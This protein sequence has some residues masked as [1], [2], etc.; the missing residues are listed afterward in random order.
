MK[1][2]YDH[3]IDIMD[4]LVV[5]YPQDALHK[6]EE[7]SYLI[8]E[9]DPVKLQ[10]F[11]RTQVDLQYA[12]NNASVAKETAKY[13]AFAQ[14][15]YTTT[16]QATGEGEEQP[17][18]TSAP[19]GFIPDL[20]SDNRNIY[21]WAGIN[22]GEY[23]CMLLQKSLSKLAAS[24]GA[25][26][27]R[28]WGKI[29]GTDK[30]YF[31]AEGTAEAPPAEEGVEVSADFESRGTG[32]NMF[33]YWVCSSPTDSKWTA[34]PDLSPSDIAAARSIKV[35]FTGDLERKIITN[36]FFAKKEKH[37]LRAQ[38]AR[39]AQATSLV[40]ARVYR[41]VEEST[42]EIEENTPEEG[43]VPIPS[44][45]DMA[46]AENWVH[47]SRSILLCNRITHM[48]PVDV[49]DP[50][51]EKKKIEAKDPFEKR[52]KPISQDAKVKGNAP[53]WSVRANGDQQMFGSSNPALPD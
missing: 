42:T 21:Q 27:L 29:S 22:F 39:I 20:I 41:L 30:D 23:N 46:K 18:A 45:K 9:N 38:I 15:L 4:F 2:L 34:L 33:G 19:V 8:K 52:L 12:R 49:E 40:P 36:P 6:F 44:T 25:S 24:N 47:Y 7:V 32:V 35:H 3:L 14:Q 37:Y 53:A 50:E 5:N 48:E 10:K 28:L 17:E 51:E 26:N 43:P 1:N 13:V 11:L 31:V 16:T